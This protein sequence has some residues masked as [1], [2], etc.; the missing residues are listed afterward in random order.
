MNSLPGV[1]STHQLTDDALFV[2]S[3]VSIRSSILTHG[4][5]FPGSSRPLNT[6]ELFIVPRS[7]EAICVSIEI[8]SGDRPA[9]C[10]EK[11]KSECGGSFASTGTSTL[12]I[13]YR[14]RRKPARIRSVKEPSPTVG[15]GSHKLEVHSI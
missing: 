13:R 8:L 2:S 12:E 9:F 1:I 5:R 15:F 6:K 14:S 3:F 4:A 10:S 7:R 11:W